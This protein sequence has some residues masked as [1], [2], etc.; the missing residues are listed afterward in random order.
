MEAARQRQRE[1]AARQREERRQRAWTATGYV[2]ASLPDGEA[3][4]DAD[5]DA[6]VDAAADAGADADADAS[7]LYFVDG[8]VAAPLRGA[9]GAPPP[10]ADSP[11][12][13]AIVVHVVDTSGRWGRGGVFSALDRR[14]VTVGQR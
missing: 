7:R 14:D 4:G 6:D 5:T 13:S 1:G 12:P 10:A 3:D 2:S 8:D 9:P 11:P